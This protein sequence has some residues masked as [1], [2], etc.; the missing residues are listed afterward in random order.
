M[1]DVLFAAD[2][3][4]FAFVL[5]SVYLFKS[6]VIERYSGGEIYA[7]PGNELLQ[8]GRHRR[9]SMAIWAGALGP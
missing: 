8:Y 4:C 3:K 7:Q 1:T 6:Q 2:E 5:R 9:I